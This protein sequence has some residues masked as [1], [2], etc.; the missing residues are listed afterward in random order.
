MVDRGWREVDAI[1]ELILRPYWTW[2]ER[3]L[4]GPMGMVKLGIR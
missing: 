4:I 2:L 1:I 3:G